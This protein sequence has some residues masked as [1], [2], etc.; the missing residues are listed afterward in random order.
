MKISRNWLQTYFTNPLPSADDISRSLTMHSFEIEEVVEKKGDYI[1]DV[2]VLP[3]RAHDCLCHYGIA[4][5]IS[6]IFNIPIN[7]PPFEITPKLITESKIFSVDVKT[8][9]VSRFKVVVLNDVVVKA[10]PDWL[11][12]RIEA[13]GGRSINNIVDVTNFVMFELGQPMHAF[14]ADKIE[15]ENKKSFIVRES[16]DAE[17]IKTLDGVD[18]ELKEGA[19]LI[20]GGESGGEN[21]LGIAGVKGGAHAEITESTKNIILEAA[22][23]D[24]ETIRRASKI[25]GIR[26]DASIRFENGLAPELPTYAI[27]YAINLIEDIASGDNF[28]IEGGVDFSKCAKNKYKVGVSLSEVNNLLGI[29]LND[30]ELEKILN[31]Y[32]FSF[33]K[34]TP[35]LEI[36]KMG[37]SLIGKKYKN[38]SSMR[39][40]APEEF[41]C[42]SLVSYL[43]VEGGIYMP[44]ISIDKYFYGEKVEEK[45]LIFGD[46]I[47]SNSQKGKIYTKSVEY[48]SGRL[49]EDKGIDHVGVYLG[50]DRVLHASKENSGVLIED[51]KES[52]SFKNIIG[53]RRMGNLDEERYVIEIPFERLDLRLPED[54][55]EEVGRLY[56]LEHIESKMPPQNNIEVEINSD[57]YK[58]DAIRKAL[59][60][61]GYSEIHTYAMV[62]NGEVEIQNPIAS[63]KA[64]MRKDL[65]K[66]MEYSLDLNAHNIQLLG[67]SD[68][69]LFEV[70]SVFKKDKEYI[71]VCLGELKKG[72][73]NIEEFTLEEAYNKFCFDQKE[74]VVSSGL[75]D[76]SYKY[77]TISPYPFALRDVALWVPEATSSSN[78]EGVIRKVGG[79][80]LVR[81]DQFDT[82]KKEDKVSFAFHLV[83][84]SMDRTLGEGEINELMDKIYKALTS[85]NWTIR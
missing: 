71:S 2:K 51:Y 83:F 76:K 58:A 32:N 5:E 52:N 65:T 12:E 20:T 74:L 31:R 61:Q 18:R 27:N 8:D 39:Y 72:K 82:F 22:T 59:I 49:I 40:D 69:K 64:F 43:F 21:I 53:F 42:S 30:S 70:G 78:V 47:F 10:S 60:S 33:K 57:F 54:I 23:F 55:V 15:G 26:T 50:E 17:K 28:E 80:I 25:L 35:R 81:C 37:N 56:G 3:N 45:D 14:D 44:S 11:R 34:V 48:M 79:E 68:L 1:F 73:K 75:S 24:P 4:K 9:K 13:M 77:K 62:K 19:I 63:D 41:S 16:K 38:P 85:N 36:E 66:G 29:S 7:N 46:L 67:I 6:A 84:Q